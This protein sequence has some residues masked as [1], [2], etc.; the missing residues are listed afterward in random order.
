MQ[1]LPVL[2]QT[3]TNSAH[4]QNLKVIFRSI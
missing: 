4:F 2:T 3:G 1:L